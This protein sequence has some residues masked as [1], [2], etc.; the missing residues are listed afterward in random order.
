MKSVFRTK[1]CPV[2]TIVIFGRR[3]ESS[4]RMIENYERERRVQICIQITWLSD[5]GCRANFRREDFEL[6]E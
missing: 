5:T 3:K 2:L 6:Y 1:I 4:V